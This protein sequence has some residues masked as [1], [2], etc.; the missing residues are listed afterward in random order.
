L[1]KRED[2]GMKEVKYK[3]SVDVKREREMRTEV[4]RRMEAEQKVDPMFKARYGKK[5]V[6]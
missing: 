1:Q 2:E 5:V 6:Q 3:R 4:F